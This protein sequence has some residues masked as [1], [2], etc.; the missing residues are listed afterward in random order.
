M[1]DSLCLADENDSDENL[2][3]AQLN[4]SITADSHRKLETAPKLDRLRAPKSHPVLTSSKK[5]GFPDVKALR[6]QRKSG[7]PGASD[8]SH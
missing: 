4:H 5:K 1:T 6:L 2:R 8:P 7:V 3:A